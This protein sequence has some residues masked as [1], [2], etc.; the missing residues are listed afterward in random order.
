MDKWLLLFFLGAILSL[1]LPIVPALFYIVLL[2][3]LVVAL[4][5]IKKYALTGLLL[6][7]CWVLLQGY[8]Y[9]TKLS[10]NDLSKSN[11]HQHSHII[12]GEV[13]TL[14]ANATNLI[15]THTNTK[16]ENTQ[17]FNFKVT[18]FDYKPLAQPFIVRLSWKKSSFLVKQ[19]YKVRLKVKLKPAHGLANSGGF[20]YQLWLRSKNIIATGYV[21]TSEENKILSDEVSFRQQQLENINKIIPKHPLSSLVIALSLGER[22]TITPAQWQI[23]TATGTQHLIAISGLHLGL[24]ASSIFLLLLMVIKILPLNFLLPTVIKNR[25]NQYNLIYMAIA[26]SLFITL[27]YATLAGFAIPT[28]RAL[29]MLNLYWLA[30]LLAINI[31]LKRWLL[32]VVFFVLITA[33]MSILS[34]S[35]W[36]S[37]Y[38]VL[39]IFLLLWRCHYFLSVNTPLAVNSTWLKSTTYKVRV[40]VKG[41]IVLQLGLSLFLLP[42]TVLFYQKISLVAF[43]A[44]IIAV[45]WMSFTAIPLSL[46][47]ML[48]IPF[49]ERLARLLFDL[50]L[51]TLDMLWQWLSFWLSNLG[52][53]SFYLFHK[54]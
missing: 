26:L 2:L 37:F 15:T 27:V 42:V 44:N 17:R 23:L 36:L 47:G 33:P 30:R 10:F 3:A 54:A 32:L 46:A 31:S 14:T 7:C 39:V 34:A 13:L 1:F 49:S 48:A 4:I 41:L 35:F 28:L 12:T 24:V 19:G 8:L 45:P 51:R 25:L 52:R 40:F 22:S 20:N 29:F 6:G 18:S 9:Q 50:C 16:N 5:I 38:A 21:L 43:A 53:Y 11:L